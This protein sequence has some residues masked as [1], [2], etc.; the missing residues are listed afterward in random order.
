[1]DDNTRVS[2]STTV[3]TALNSKPGSR[4]RDIETYK[5]VVA[6]KL[7]PYI[8]SVLLNACSIVDDRDD[9]KAI[10]DWVEKEG[11]EEI[12]R[13]GSECLR[14]LLDQYMLTI[15]PHFS[16]KTASGDGVVEVTG[17]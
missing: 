3:E 6:A 17:E 16:S 8:R 5:G 7:R 11:G 13:A 14:I 10:R 15:L 1:M 2:A 12:V 4:D 9:Y